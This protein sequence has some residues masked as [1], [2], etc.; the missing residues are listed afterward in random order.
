MLIKIIALILS[1]Q[2][3]FSFEDHEANDKEEVG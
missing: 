1:I 2:W 3:I